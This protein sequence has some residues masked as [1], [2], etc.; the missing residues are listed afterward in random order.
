[1]PDTAI[2]NLTE[3]ARS[4]LEK[5]EQATQALAQ[6]KAEGKVKIEAINPRYRVFVAPVERNTRFLINPAERTFF[7]ITDPNVPGGKRNLSTDHD[8]WIE[9]HD[10]IADIDTATPEGKRILE[11]AQAHPELCRDIADPLTEPW[12]MLKFGQCPTSRSDETVAK[13]LDIDKLL[14][15]DPRSVAVKNSMATRARESYETLNASDK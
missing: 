10:G 11:W 4:V 1:M 7:S 9:F 2:G 5:Q 6:A 14:A 12:A 13:G 15:G 3:E 8:I